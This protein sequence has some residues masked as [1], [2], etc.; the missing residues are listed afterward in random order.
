VLE[1]LSL[2]MAWVRGETLDVEER[3]RRK[4]PNS[5]RNRSE[6]KQD[7]TPKGANLLLAWYLDLSIL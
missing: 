2:R 6:K 4:E 5:I 1:P 7:G 3:M